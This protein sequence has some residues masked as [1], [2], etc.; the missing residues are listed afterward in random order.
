MPFDDPVYERLVG[1]A[2][3]MDIHVPTFMELT[4]SAAPSTF[5]MPD[6]ATLCAANIAT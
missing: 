3:F 4:W 5:T 6:S 2:S 1:Y